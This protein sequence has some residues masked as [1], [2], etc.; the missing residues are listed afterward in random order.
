[1]ENRKD[2]LTE[3][4][5]DRLKKMTGERKQFS[6]IF[7]Q[8]LR[9]K[10]VRD[11]KK[12]M[13]DSNLNIMQLVN[14][15]DNLGRLKKAV[16]LYPLVLEDRLELLLVTA[17]APPVH[18]TVDIK[19]TELNDLISRFRKVLSNAGSD[20]RPLARQLYN[21]LIQ[22][23]RIALE[24]AGAETIIYAPDRT[25]RYIPLS[26]L[27]DGQEWLVERFKIHRITAYSLSDLNTKPTKALRIFA[28]AFSSGNLEFKV[29]EQKFRFS[30]LPFARLE[31]EGLA[32]MIP[33]TKT[34]FDQ[35]FTP[36]AIEQEA[37]FHT[38]VHLA[39]H[40]AFMTGHPD[41]SFIVFGNGQRLTLRDVEDEWSGVLP[42]VEL[43][44]LSACETGIGGKLDN[45][46]EILGFGALMEWAGADASIAT[47]WS[48]DD[49]G[50][51]L[52]M[53]GF[54]KRLHEGHITKAEALQQAQLI[55]IRSAD[56]PGTETRGHDRRR[57]G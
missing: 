19:Q 9:S 15:Q 6:K 49:G 40:A 39:T 14:L 57:C 33:G 41:A 8:F 54:Y 1:M 5:R 51:Q 20:A 53:N 10:E 16:L 43:I 7:N 30:G 31:I 32:K 24:A 29:G 36:E 21:V 17:Y 25:L 34:I 4:E 22:P 26:A 13:S 47:L 42:N 3:S 12:S 2:S 55:L 50:T 48:V 46:D 38:I 28:G 45:G 23:L 56:Q 52:L 18:R 37:G 27:Y 44:V 35:N 11:W